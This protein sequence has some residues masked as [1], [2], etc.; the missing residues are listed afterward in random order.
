MGNWIT[1]IH[2]IENHILSFY[3]HLY[4]YDL[5]LSYRQHQTSHS[6]LISGLDLELLL[7]P[8]FNTELLNDVYSFKPYK[9]SGLGGLHIFLFQ[10]YWHIVGGLV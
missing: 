2:N 5:L 8:L 3:S 10:Q 1:G 4:S 9:A 6:R 7:I